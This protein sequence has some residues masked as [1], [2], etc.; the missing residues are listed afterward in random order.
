MRRSRPSNWVMVLFATWPA[1]WTATKRPFAVGNGNWSSLSPCRR[2]APEKKGGTT[3]VDQGLPHA[4]R[5]LRHAHLR[6]HGRRPDASGRALDQ[7]VVAS[8]P[9]G[10]D[11]LWLP[12]RRPVRGEP[13]APLPLR[14]T[15][16]AEEIVAPTPSATGSAI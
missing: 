3:P 10:L 14:P 5:R 7:P 11:P 8:Y 13:P 4:G 12:H 15:S 1:S 2:D 9:R 6:L 16:G